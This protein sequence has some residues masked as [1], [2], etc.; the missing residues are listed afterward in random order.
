MAGKRVYLDTSAYLAV[1]FGE[2]E[3][4][5]LQ[6]FL[7]DKVL[8]SSILLII[9]SERNMVRLSRQ[10]ILNPDQYEKCLC[11]LKKDI[12]LFL[13]KEVSLDLCLSGLFP[14][15]QTPRSNDLI[16]LR[17]ARWFQN[18]GGLEKFVTLDQNQKRSAIDFGL[19]VFG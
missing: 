2:K 9:E 7:E 14:P 19:A 5:S 18:N 13:I 11:Q 6:K 16:H 12:D 8:C 17:T 10:K 3:G 15:I 1:L 4:I